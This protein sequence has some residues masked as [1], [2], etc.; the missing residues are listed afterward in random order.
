MDKQKDRHAGLKSISQIVPLSNTEILEG[1]VILHKKITLNPFVVSD[2]EGCNTSLGG[3]IDAESSLYTYLYSENT[4][5]ITNRFY[6]QKK[7]N[8]DY[9]YDS[10]EDEVIEAVS[11]SLLGGSKKAFSQSASPENYVAKCV[12]NQCRKTAK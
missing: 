12:W 6:S 3:E 1:K 4:R 8:S 11:K 5:K 7:L 9:E 10:F 2:S